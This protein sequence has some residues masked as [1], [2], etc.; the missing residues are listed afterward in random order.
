M[1][2]KKPIVSWAK[3]IVLTKIDFFMHNYII[4][5][6]D[7]SR[8]YWW[9][10]VS[11]GKD[12]FTMAYALYLW[13][14]KNGYSFNGEGIYIKQW[15]EAGIAN[16]LRDAIPWMPIT[17]IHGEE[18]TQK[19]TKYTVGSQAPCSKCSHVRK[20]LGD[21]FIVQH[22]KQGYYNI[23]A[24]G[25]HFTDMTISYLWR[26]FWGIDTVQFAK[27]LEK[28]NPL[29]QLDL[30]DNYYLAKPLCYV[31]EYECEQFSKS[32]KYVPICCGCPACRFPSRRDIVEDSLG[33]LFSSQL[34]EFDVHG[35]KDYLKRIN[36]PDSLQELSLRGREMKCSRLSPEF[37]DFAIQYWRSHEKRINIAFDNS[38]FLDSIGCS[39]LQKHEW[40]HSSHLFL[41]K[42][43]AETEIP[44]VEKM[45]IAT[46]GPLWGAIGYYDSNFRSSI[47][48][49]QTEIF[50]IN[51]DKLWSQVT[52]ILRE[53]YQ[54][55]S[56][57]SSCKCQTFSH[58]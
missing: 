10:S 43:Y 30:I 58:S 25:L 23:L 34:W 24:R 12:S 5:S 3:D 48:S 56:V 31:R 45:L 15:N 2:P 41:P 51:I 8:V 37:S 50:G 26:D 42:Y 54:K 18:E 14:R 4:P 57:S 19:R 29:V 38:L 39:Y 21:Q 13:Y 55:M 47:L 49:I 44:D 7:P 28:G 17:V 1:N 16:H 36:A 40:N 20:A 6:F 32:F 46:V 9:I 22:F 27:T 52:P 11:G 35:I 33:M 53:Y